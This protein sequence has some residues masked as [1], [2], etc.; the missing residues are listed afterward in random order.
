MVRSFIILASFP[1]ISF[2]LDPDPSLGPY[3]LILILVLIIS[4]IMLFLLL[5]PP[6][7]LVPSPSHHIHPGYSWKVCVP[8]NE[9][10]LIFQS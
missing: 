5:L 2:S 10:S 3:L 8:T 4:L 7:I 6:L 9:V 1:M